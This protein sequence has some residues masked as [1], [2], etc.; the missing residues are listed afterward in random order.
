MRIF[1][2]ISARELTNMYIGINDRDAVV[3]GENTHRYEYGKE[4]V[5]FFRY[6]QDAEM[7]GKI[8]KDLG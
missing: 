7:F 8:L 1:R 3:M 4:Y 2:C 5:H 6:S